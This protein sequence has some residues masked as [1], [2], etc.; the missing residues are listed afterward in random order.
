MK[1]TWIFLFL[2]I[3]FVLSAQENYMSLCFVGN[4]PLGNFSSTNN[5]TSDGFALNGFGGEYSGTYFITSNVGFGGNIRFTSNTIDDN[6]ARTLLREEIPDDLPLENALLGI[7]IWKQVYLVI[8]PYFSLPLPNLNFDAFALIGIN[9]IMPPEMKITAFFDEVSYSRNFSV[10]S[11]SYAVDLGIALRYHLNENYSLRMFSSYF[12]SN[13]KGTVRE[14]FDLD[15]DGNS[16][17]EERDQSLTIQS[18]NLGIGI[19]Y[20]F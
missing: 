7:G 1:S 3:S 14:E 8:G 17:I 4:L 15:G 6:A 9:V 12:Q 2:M 20:R 11:V 5:L 10:Q 19:V 13:S 16:D 18:V